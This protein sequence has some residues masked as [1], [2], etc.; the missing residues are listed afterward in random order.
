MKWMSSRYREEVDMKSRPLISSDE[1]R[2]LTI[3]G[4]ITENWGQWNEK[5]PIDQWQVL[6]KAGI[7]TQRPAPG[8]ADE[9]NTSDDGGLGREGFFMSR[10]VR[11]SVVS[12]VLPPSTG[13]R[14]KMPIDATP[15]GS[16]PTSRGSSENTKIQKIPERPAQAKP[17][18]TEAPWIKQGAQS[19]KE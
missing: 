12:P 14:P 6:D 13:P 17:G 4:H 5:D 16:D 1:W 9:G 10:A 18:P 15:L 19:V 8:A 2:V 7:I 3:N 11:S